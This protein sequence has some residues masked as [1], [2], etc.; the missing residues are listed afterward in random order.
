MKISILTFPKAI[1]YGTALQAVAL[2]K[3]LEDLNNEVCFLE[4]NCK[5]ID[6]SNSLFDFSQM[7]N[8]KYTIA[9]LYNLPVALKRK[10]KSIQILRFTFRESRNVLSKKGLIL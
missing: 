4:H 2:K 1:N 10:T 3:K 6:N 9:H 5:E 7:L 8:P